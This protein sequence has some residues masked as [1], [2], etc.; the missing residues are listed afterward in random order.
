MCGIVCI[1]QVHTKWAMLCCPCNGISANR[2]HLF[3]FAFICIESRFLPFFVQSATVKS[4]NCAPAATSLA[5]E[6]HGARRK[7]RA[8]LFAPH[9]WLSSAGGELTLSCLHCSCPCSSIFLCHCFAYTFAVTF[10]FHSGYPGRRSRRERGEG[11][12][13]SL[14]PNT[15]DRI[16]CSFIC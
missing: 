14:K 13:A 11:L 2:F 8:W 15:M 1:I 7:R 10:T 6:L 4:T 9:S 5:N 12:G 16:V 3:F